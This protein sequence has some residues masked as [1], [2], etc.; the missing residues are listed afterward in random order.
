ML[1]TALETSFLEW[2]SQHHSR[3][4]DQQAKNIH[5]EHGNENRNECN[6]GRVCN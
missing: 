1:V 5:F 4:H 6:G 2:H 3:C